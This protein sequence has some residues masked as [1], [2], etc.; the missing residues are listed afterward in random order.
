VIAQINDKPAGMV[1]AHHIANHRTVEL[2]SMWVAPFARGR[3]VGDALVHA[4]VSW[5]EEQQAKRVILAVRNDNAHAIALYAR[6]GF[7]D[8]GPAP[9]LGA[10]HPKERLMIRPSTP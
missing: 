8:S 2:I 6:H 1:G 3:G 9:D 5:A 4:V 7:A 10:G